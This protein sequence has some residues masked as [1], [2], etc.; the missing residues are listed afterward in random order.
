[1]SYCWLVDMVRVG[2][3]DLFGVMC[4]W[5]NQVGDNSVTGAQ[6]NRAV[7][8]LFFDPFVAAFGEKRNSALR[9]DTFEL[10]APPCESVD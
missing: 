9:S 1:M 6:D 8:R 5:K 10:V 7:A 3:V 4:K 2:M